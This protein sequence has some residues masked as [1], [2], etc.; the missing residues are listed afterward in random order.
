MPVNTWVCTI[1]TLCPAKTPPMPAI[2]ALERLSTWLSVPGVSSE[3]RPS[4]FVLPSVDLDRPLPTVRPEKSPWSIQIYIEADPLVTPTGPVPTSTQRLVTDSWALY[5]QPS[6]T[7]NQCMCLGNSPHAQISN[8][9]Y[10][11]PS[12]LFPSYCCKHLSCTEL[13]HIALVY[14]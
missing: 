6:A 1:G 2:L 9:L 14:D 13:H 7:A 12:F 5:S 3:R 10:S 11:T 4:S 8:L